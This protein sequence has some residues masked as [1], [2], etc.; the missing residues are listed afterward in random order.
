MYGTVQ[1]LLGMESRF[2]H[3]RERQEAGN[4]RLNKVI[5]YT[6]WMLTGKAPG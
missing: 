5:F 2:L 1:L 6:G 4:L 3:S